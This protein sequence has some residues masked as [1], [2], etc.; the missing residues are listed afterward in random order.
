MIRDQSNLTPD[1]S[2]SAERVEGVKRVD[3]LDPDDYDDT[4][5]AMSA[6]ET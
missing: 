2:N 1:D 5:E 4:L 6:F 3:L